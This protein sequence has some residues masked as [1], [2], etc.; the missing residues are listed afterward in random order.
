MCILNLLVAYIASLLIYES[1]QY[2]MQ[3]HHLWVFLTVYCITF[4]LSLTWHAPIIFVM[5][6]PNFILAWFVETIA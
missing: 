6:I 4:V 5:T 2:K 1:H 3:A